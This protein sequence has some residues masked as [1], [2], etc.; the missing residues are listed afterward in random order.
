MIVAWFTSYVQLAQK[1]LLAHPMELLGDVGQVEAQF[2]SFGVSVNLA[3]DRC[4]ICAECT[5]G[6]KIILGAPDGT[7]R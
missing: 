4:M 2:G 7:S 5:I 1:S 3:Q 6:S